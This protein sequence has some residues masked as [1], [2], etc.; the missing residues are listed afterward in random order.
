MRAVR[1]GDRKL[2]IEGN[3]TFLYDVRRDPGERNDLARLHP[4][5]VRA[6]KLKLDGWERDVDAEA[7]RRK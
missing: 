1:E 3:H 7:A 6:L 2:V 5:L 4:E